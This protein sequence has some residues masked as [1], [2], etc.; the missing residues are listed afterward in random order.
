MANY[1]LSGLST[2]LPSGPAGAGKTRY[3]AGGVWGTTPQATPPRTTSKYTSFARDET[4]NIVGQSENNFDETPVD[5]GEMARRAAEN[6]AGTAVANHVTANANNTGSMPGLA[7]AASARDPYRNYQQEAINLK[8]AEEA[9]LHTQQ[10]A[11][12]AARRT[13]EGVDR[14]GVPIQVPTGPSLQAQGQANWSRQQVAQDDA[15]SQNSLMGLMDAFKSRGLLGPNQT[16][17]SASSGGTSAGGT[18]TPTMPGTGSGMPSGAPP[19]VAPLA[20]VNT[21]GAASAAFGR[22]KDQVGQTSAGAIAGLRSSLGGRGMLG[23]GS[24]GRQTAGVI[25]AG[26]AQ[27]GD[28]SRQQAITDATR[29]EH[30]AQTNYEGGLTQ[31]G[32]DLSASNAGHLADLEARGQDLTARG[33]NIG[34]EEFASKAEAEAR[35]AQLDAILGLYKSYGSRPGAGTVY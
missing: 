14:N 9:R 2:A 31:R 8:N 24:E 13:S 20:P 27:L 5:P 25:N 6:A 28:V 19:H 23:S 34:H 15:Q 17:S 11:D 30:E 32:Q 7:S 33:Q 12:D 16:T 21:S 3:P 1:P 35:Q 26:Q 4:G 29:A 18:W 22:A 10:R